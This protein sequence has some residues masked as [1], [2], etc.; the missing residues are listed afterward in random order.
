[1]N[2]TIET[3]SSFTLDNQF[4]SKNKTESTYNIFHEQLFLL[5]RFS[6]KYSAN[7]ITCRL[8][9]E[10]VK[11]IEIQNLPG[12][13]LEQNLAIMNKTF[14][15]SK[16]IL[17]FKVEWNACHTL[18]LNLCAGL[19]K[20]WWERL[21]D[22]AFILNYIWANNWGFKLFEQRKREQCIYNLKKKINIFHK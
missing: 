15:S 13:Y 21:P 10:I 20:I 1:M 6:I 19:I 11:S 9:Y 16:A 8:E 12:C 17:W 7:L 2:I 22:T 3:S 18:N 5:Y 14:H 4:S